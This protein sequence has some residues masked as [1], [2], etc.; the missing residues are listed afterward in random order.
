MSVTADAFATNF[1]NGFANSTV[2]PEF[3]F[4]EIKVISYQDKL[5][6]EWHDEQL[7]PLVITTFMPS[8]ILQGKLSNQFQEQKSF[9]NAFHS[10]NSIKELKQYIRQSDEFCKKISDIMTERA[11]IENRYA[12]E[13]STLS[14]KLIKCSTNF[15]GTMS[16]A[17]HELAVEFDSEAENHRLFSNSLNDDI[18]KP[19][20]TILES[21][22]KKRKAIES[23]MERM[24]KSY[25][26][27]QNIDF[28]YR[29]KLFRI[30]NLIGEDDKQKDIEQKTKDAGF[31]RKNGDRLHR[32]LGVIEQKCIS[33]TTNVEYARQNL[34]G[35]I[36]K[37]FIETF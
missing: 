18:V 6:I 19:I 29:Q 28:K 17:Y 25:H 1:I 5:P 7:E 33:S 12:K 16:N 8:Q 34:N 2:H 3:N 20:K 23:G 36:A 14:H 35:F 11:T 4:P 10:F 32:S 15:M 30:A 26:D 22:A 24:T 9:E 27:K 37:V 13:I 31:M 21:Y